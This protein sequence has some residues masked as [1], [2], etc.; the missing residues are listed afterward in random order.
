MTEKELKEKINKIN[1]ELNNINEKLKD[2]TDTAI[3]K[4]M[5]A[6]DE[7]DDKIKEAR[8]KLNETKTTLKEK[9]AKGKKTFTNYLNKIEES[10]N[11]GRAKLAD[12]KEAR[13]KAKLEKYIDYRLEYTSDCIAL[14][15]LAAYEAKL[16]FIEALEAEAEYEELYDED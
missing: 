13:D 1:D 12:K 11:E 7:L 3:I 2:S 16:S 14:A 4:G 8:E 15:L 9:Q 5:Y 6:K 10:I